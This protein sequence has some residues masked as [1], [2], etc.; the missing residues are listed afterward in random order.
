MGDL[1]VG[2]D[3][4]FGRS[5]EPRLKELDLRDPQADSRTST[6]PTTPS[7][8]LTVFQLSHTSNVSGEALNR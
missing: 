6:T 7:L 2:C 8:P 5:N 4:S 1:C 3:S